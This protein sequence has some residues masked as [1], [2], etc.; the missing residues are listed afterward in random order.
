MFPHVKIKQKQTK[1]KKVRVSKLTSIFQ[2]IPGSK[3]EQLQ[4]LRVNYMPDTELIKICNKLTRKELSPSH[5][6]RKEN[7]GREFAQGHS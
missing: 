4:T 5:C 6:D 3:L 1:P 2:I 7:R